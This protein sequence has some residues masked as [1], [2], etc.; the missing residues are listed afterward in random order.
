MCLRW[1]AAGMLEAEQQFRRIIGYR[2]LATLANAVERHVA[3]ERASTHTTARRRT[4]RSPPSP[5]H[6][7]RTATTKFHDG[8]DILREGAQP[9][10]DEWEEIVA[11]AL[12]VAR[13]RWPKPVGEA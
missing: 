11:A 3:T 10:S 8:R 2:D 9:S 12:Q 1:T 4:L 13:R 7:T 5:D 6:H